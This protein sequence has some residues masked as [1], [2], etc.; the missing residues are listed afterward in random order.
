MVAYGS[1]NSVNYLLKSEPLFKIGNMLL[2]ISLLT[3]ILFL[4]VN[5]KER[6]I[7]HFPLKFVNYWLIIQRS[8]HGLDY[9]LEAEI[10]YNSAA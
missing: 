2:N 8:L 10:I 7:S 1:Q 5:H 3:G 4:R 9:F 6:T